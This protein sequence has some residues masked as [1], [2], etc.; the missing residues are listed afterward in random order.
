[1]D[2]T[3]WSGTKGQL[4]VFDPNIRTDTSRYE[5]STE[6]VGASKSKLNAIRNGCMGS[7]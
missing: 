2:L 3:C 4:G 1:M 5:S 7:L 6:S